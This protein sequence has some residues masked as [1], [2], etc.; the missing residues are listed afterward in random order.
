MNKNVWIKIFFFM[1][2]TLHYLVFWF[3]LCF[4]VWMDFSGQLHI[5]KNPDQIGQVGEFGTYAG[6]IFFILSI[7]HMIYCPNDLLMN[8]VTF[9]LW[10]I[11]PSSVKINTPPPPQK[12]IKKVIFVCLFLLS[13]HNLSGRKQK[14]HN[15]FITIFFVLFCLFFCPWNNLAFKQTSKC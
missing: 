4:S 15:I 11:L 14:L 10:H 13:G 2:L 8:V 5:K 9:L 12:K 6:C 1:L 3:F 7:I